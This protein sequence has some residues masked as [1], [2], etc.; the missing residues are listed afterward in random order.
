M[1]MNRRIFI[2]SL[3][4]AA[5]LGA[6]DA[7][8]QEQDLVGV[9]LG[10]RFF[11]GEANGRVGKGPA[12]GH[13][14]IDEDFDAA[15]EATGGGIS[16]TG[17]LRGG[18]TFNIQGWQYTSDGSATQSET[19]GFGSL[20]LASGAEVDADIEIRY[21]STKFVFGLTP[22]RDPFRVGL[23]VGGKVIHWGTELTLD[24]GES[25]S[26]RM[27]MIYP[28][29]ELEI[30]FRIG[31]AIEL[32]AEGGAG[33]PSFAKQSLEIQNPLEA[34]VGLRLNLAGVLIEGGYQMYDALLIRDEGRADEESANVNLAGFYFELAAR[35]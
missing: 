13:V 27:R 32:K 35:F 2:P 29:A 25:E 33:M 7:S 9:E 1:S 19:Q 22:E 3:V 6:V 23:G 31:E 12:L 20:V 21:V 24:T 4:A 14:D 28:S 8:A 17:F 16:L 5:L 11:M 10:V 30:S 18:N 26:V 15:D 34:R